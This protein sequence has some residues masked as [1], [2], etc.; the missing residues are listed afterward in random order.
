M[1]PCTVG[2]S[3]VQPGT[4]GYNRVQPCTARCSPIQSGTARYSLLQP[5]TARYSQVQQGTVI[6]IS[7]ILHASPD[8]VFLY[9]LLSFWS[10]L[11]V[12]EELIGPKS[13][14]HKAIHGYRIFQ[15][16]A[17]LFYRRKNSYCIE[18]YFSFYR[19]GKE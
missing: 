13:V 17:S 9:F 10:Q 2:Y 1:Q 4:A 14:R 12:E 18:I 5:S 6:V 15:A 19:R 16:F 7:T 3:W 8:A 11:S